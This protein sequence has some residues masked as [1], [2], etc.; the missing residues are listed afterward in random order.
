MLRLLLLATVLPISAF[1]AG[2]YVVAVSGTIQ[3]S[4]TVPVEFYIGSSDGKCAGT[5]DAQT[6]S[7]GAF[8][9]TR[10]VG[11]SWREKFVVV[12]RTFSLCAREGN[13]WV[14][15]W[16]L[17]TGPPPGRIAFDCSAINAKARA[18]RVEWDGRILQ[19]VQPNSRLVRDAYASA[20]RASSGAA[21]PER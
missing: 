12:V 14:E 2:D 17:R 20:P 10:T 8:S 13:K 6:D 19:S 21:K 18:C 7:T 3:S 15:L 16:S 5:A 4:T 1:G 11:R 9:F